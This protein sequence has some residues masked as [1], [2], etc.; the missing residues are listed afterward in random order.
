VNLSIPVDHV[1]LGE[2]E[3]LAGESYLL[4]F[5]E[6]VDGERNVGFRDIAPTTR[7]DIACQTE[8]VSLSFNAMLGLTYT[9]QTSEDIVA[10]LWTTLHTLTA[11]EYRETITC[12]GAGLPLP[13]SACFRVLIDQP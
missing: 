10:G 7:L 11:D 6:Q 1:Q 13:D 3:I 4:G 9:V 12:G 2:I 8:E 5:F